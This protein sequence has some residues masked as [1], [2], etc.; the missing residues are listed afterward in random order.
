[1]NRMILLLMWLITIA[2]FCVLVY[3]QIFA[4]HDSMFWKYRYVM[5]IFFIVVGRNTIIASRRWNIRK[6]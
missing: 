6:K 3:A 4:G 1:M 5:V 2:V